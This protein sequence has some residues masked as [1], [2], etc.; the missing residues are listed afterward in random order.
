MRAE[1][2]AI[3]LATL[4]SLGPVW[5]FFALV[6]LLVPSS[7]PV[8]RRLW[9]HRVVRWWVLGVG[10]AVALSLAWIL[11]MKTGNV[12]HQPRPLYG[13]SARAATFQ[14]LNMW[15]SIFLQ[16]LVGVAG[17]FDVFMPNPIYWIYLVLTG[18]LVVFATVLGGWAHR[19]RFLVMAFGAVVPI[20]LI[21]VAEVNQLGWIIGG[22]YLLPLLVGMPLLAAFILE[23]SVLQA[24]HSRSFIRLF[25]L[26]LLPVHLALLV[27]S[28][29][30]WQAGAN[31][32][33]PNP[34]KGT[35]HPPTGSITPLVLMLV[36][37]LVVGWAFWTAP[38]RI[39][40]LPDLDEP[41][42][43]EVGTAD[44]E[45]G[46]AESSATPSGTVLVQLS[47]PPG[48]GNGNGHGNGPHR[49]GEAERPGTASA[50]GADSLRS[51]RN[52][53]TGLK[54]PGRGTFQ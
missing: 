29:R 21:Q 46:T 4:R 8:L 17:W 34:F 12:V 9:G 48:N 52:G 13:Y 45:A 22:R 20:G 44:D 53:D 47:P 28:M 40:T 30:R 15:G 5:L 31:Q 41:L 16:G 18:S 36:G 6:A 2:S 54:V 24:R 42:V 35:W 43:A 7:R 33:H 10:L 27:F 1:N 19:W 50:I 51:T 49:P 26:V 37:L 32:S 3:L 39:A 38:R 11:G 23:R 14:Y 25:C